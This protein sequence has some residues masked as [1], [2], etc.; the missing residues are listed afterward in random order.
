MGSFVK[1]GL[2]ESD[3]GHETG[4]LFELRKEFQLA[5]TAK[6]GRSTW[7]RWGRLILQHSCSSGTTLVRPG[8]P[9][10]GSLRESNSERSEGSSPSIQ[11]CH[12]LETAIQ[13]WSIGMIDR[14]SA[15]FQ[16]I[17]KQ[18][19]ASLAAEQVI[20]G[21]GGRTPLKECCVEQF[22]DE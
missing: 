16:L 21:W 15:S 17:Q 3:V 18:K 9:G 6:L 22:C 19:Y 12:D 7:M 13:I 14:P 10:P 1:G 11:L 8:S 2:F 20:G 5:P 4:P